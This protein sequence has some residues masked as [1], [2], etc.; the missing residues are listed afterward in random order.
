MCIEFTRV[1]P[2]FVV[3]CFRPPAGRGLDG[4]RPRPEQPQ[5]IPLLEDGLLDGWHATGR[6]A[7]YQQ[8]PASLAHTSCAVRG[9]TIENDLFGPMG[10]PRPVGF[11]R[12]TA[13]LFATVLCS[14]L[15]QP[16]YCS[17]L[18]FSIQSTVLLSSCSTTGR[19][20][21]SRY[22]T[23]S[24]LSSVKEAPAKVIHVGTSCQR[25]KPHVI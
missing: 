18:T 14:A 17:S 11:M 24:P 7:P 8:L 16:W 20:L 15:S 12:W 25:I 6:Y 21:C 22:R 5:L 19:S 3:Y 2:L 13:A 9:I 23:Y 4:D 10:P 1:N